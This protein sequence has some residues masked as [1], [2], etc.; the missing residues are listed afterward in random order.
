MGYDGEKGGVPRVVRDTIQYMRLNGNALVASRVFG[1]ANP[2]TG[3]E[4]EGLFRRNPSNSALNQLIQAY[5]RGLSFR[6]RLAVAATDTAHHPGHVVSLESHGNVHMAAVLL[7]K[8]LHALPEPL[9]PEKM[10]PLIERCPQLS[11]DASDMSSIIYIRESILPELPHC[12]YILL[13]HVFREWLHLFYNFSDN[14]CHNFAR[15][16]A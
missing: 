9:F 7:K 14:I 1:S 10:Y 15:T 16:F 8:Y 5:N 3:L 12:A 6:Q 13:T 11:N 4:E 2:R